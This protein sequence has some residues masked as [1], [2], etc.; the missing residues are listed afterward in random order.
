R[1]LLDPN[2]LSKDGTVAL[3]GTAVSEDAKYLAYGIQDAGSDW[4]TWKVLDVASGKT[5]DDELKW[6]KVSGVAWTKDGKGF[7]YGRFDEPTGSKFTALNLNQKVFYHKLG[8]KQSEDRLVY[9]RPDH[10]RWG[11]QT[12]VTDDGKYLVLTTWQGTDA[13]YRVSYK[14]L[15]K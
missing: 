1:V 5:L 12:E 8:T 15:T 3:G 14:D 7:F 6:V 9:R 11:F 13:R 2:K 10:P 4:R